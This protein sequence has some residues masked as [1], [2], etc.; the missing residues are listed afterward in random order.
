M[1]GET[2]LKAKHLHTIFRNA[3]NGYSVAKFVTYDTNEEDFTATGYFHELQEDVIYVLHG[4]YVEH[5]RYGMQFQ[6]ASYERMQPNDEESL[7]RYFSSSLFSGIGKKSAQ[8]IVMTLGEEA[9]TKIKQDPNVLLEVKSLNFK[10]RESIIRGI[11]EHDEEEDSIVFFTK[12]GLSVRNIVKLEAAY[13]E[14]AVAI[15][16]ENPYRMVTDIDGIGFA[17][18]DKLAANLSFEKDHPYR[19]KA[20][21][22]SNVMELCMSSGDSYTTRIAIQRRMQKLFGNEIELESYLEQLEMERLL[23]REDERIYHHTQYD[24]EK[25]IAV[26]LNEFAYTQETIDENELDSKLNALKER[27]H[28]SY[29]SIQREAIRSFFNTPLSIITGGPGTGK[30]TIVQGI[31]ALAKI[32]LPNERIALC[33]PTGRAAKRLAEVCDYPAMTLH[34]LLRWDLETNTFQANAQEP[35]PYE[36]VIIDE[37]SMVDAWLFYHLAMACANVKKLLLI[38]DEDQLPSVGCGCVLR[39]ILAA[40]IIKT[41]RL[42]KIFRQHE[43][44]DVI[45]LA[46]QVK[47]GYEDI[48][49][50]AK[51]VAFFPAESHEIKDMVLKIVQNAF[52]KGFSDTDVQVLAPMYGGVAGIDALNIALQKM[53]NPADGYK[54]EVKVGYRIFREHDK[55][56]Q[57]KNQPDD[58]VY[59]GDIGTILEIISADED[60]HHQHCIIADFDGVLVEYRGEAIYHLT[61]AYCISIHKAQGSEYPIVVLPIVADYRYMLQKRLVYTA[62]TRAKKSLVLLG[63]REVFRRSLESNEHHTR[64]TTLLSRILEYN[65]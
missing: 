5:Y 21:V 30:T 8:D 36:V 13:G 6:V 23:I 48:I 39:D 61:H 60:I 14:Q 16:K 3:E 9:I 65:E 55:V 18:A 40:N 29:D 33:A 35:L 22:L 32:F 62:I 24:A 50:D 41:T 28:I 11:N 57:L 19:I 47:E 42:H 15:V 1:N 56:L 49:D 20:A 10:K 58:G 38:G 37:F 54:K 27:Y 2:V 52:E 34:S 17:T 46:H 25:G 64:K 26:F 59:N 12:C 63:N 44:S 31:L 4:A 45:T 7:I 53:I 43:G 51:D